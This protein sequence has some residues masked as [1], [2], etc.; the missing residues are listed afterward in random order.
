MS[1]GGWR[2]LVV[3]WIC[4]C[5][6]SYDCELKSLLHEYIVMK[7][8]MFVFSGTESQSAFTT[9]WKISTRHGHDPMENE[10]LIRSVSF[11]V[12]ATGRM[13]DKI[14]ATIVIHIHCETQ[15]TFLHQSIFK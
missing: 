11:Q 4:V 2:F 14:A 10:T 3:G 7:K 12:C 13:S 6:F 5:V 9:C 15:L 8:I 1:I